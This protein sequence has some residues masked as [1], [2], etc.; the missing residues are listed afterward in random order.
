MGSI[1]R[2][3]DTEKAIVKLYLNG[4]KPKEIAERLGC[5][6]KTVYKATS[7]YRKLLSMGINVDL[8]G[9]NV[10]EHKVVKATGVST[11]ETREH[12]Q[13]SIDVA[14]IV[15][16]V[17]ESVIRVYT[18]TLT[19][20]LSR[21]IKEHEES[22]LGA[23]NELLK[24]IDRLC[25]EINELGNLIRRLGTSGTQVVPKL[26]KPTELVKTIEVEVPDFVRDNPWVEIL[27]VRGRYPQV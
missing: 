11:G 8:S 27:R 19:N 25:C 18:D 14:S 3:S 6:V 17:V 2:L 23:I 4:L 1:P 16:E 7:K 21:T 24:S 22:L 10:S 12:T 26:E 13:P 15:K 9:V 5:S 20:V